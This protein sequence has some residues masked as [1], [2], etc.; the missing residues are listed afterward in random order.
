[1]TLEAAQQAKCALIARKLDLKPGARVLDIGCGWGGL[2]IHLAQNHGAHVTGITLSSEQL[3]VAQ[4]RVEKL[5]MNGPLEFRLEDYR[6][7][8]GDSD[9]QIRRATWREREGQLL[10]SFGVCASIKKKNRI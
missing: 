5:G 8:Q 4:A 2:A 6:R 9:P 7:T 1:M 3:A 10:V